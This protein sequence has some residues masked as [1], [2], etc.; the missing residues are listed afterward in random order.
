ETHLNQVS[1]PSNPP[2]TSSPTP[3]LAITILTASATTPL[4]TPPLGEKMSSC[5][6]FGL[7]RE[8]RFANPVVEVGHQCPQTLISSKQGA[9]EDFE[10]IRETQVP[11]LEYFRLHRAAESCCCYAPLYLP[12]KLSI[13]VV[14]SVAIAA[15]ADASDLLD[16]FIYTTNKKYVDYFR[17]LNPLVSILLLT[18]SSP[19]IST[20]A[21]RAVTSACL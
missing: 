16:L 17:H 14:D 9:I 4:R 8:L 5:L 7:P 11:V 6:K 12:A 19:Y 1:T 13:V 15:A 20:F 18:E 2:R 10:G 3:P 21:K